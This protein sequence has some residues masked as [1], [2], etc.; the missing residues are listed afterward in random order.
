MRFWP[1]VL[2]LLFLFSLPMLALSKEQRA[3][4][5]ALFASS[6]CQH[7]HTIGGVGGHRGPDLSN[8]GR[9]AKK[10]VMRDQILN[11]SQIMPA[12]DDVLQP[13]EIDDLIAYLRSCRVKPAK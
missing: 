5:A 7:C 13:Q 8:V 2:A 3:R 10:A 9:T 11:G 12:F 4:G 1:A 6:G